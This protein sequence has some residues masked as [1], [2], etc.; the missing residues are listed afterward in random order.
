MKRLDFEI[1][2]K[3]LFLTRSLF[4]KFQAMNACTW[5]WR[6]TVKQEL[7]EV[8]LWQSLMAVESMSA[9]QNKNTATIWVVSETN[10]AS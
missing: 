8:P 3:P 7:K 9:F 2:K 5:H 10:D 1:Y 4:A 6:W